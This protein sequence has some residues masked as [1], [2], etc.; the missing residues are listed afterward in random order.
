VD[1]S[2]STLAPTVSTM[3]VTLSPLEQ[4]RA[5]IHDAEKEFAKT[6]R[7]EF[8]AIHNRVNE[9]DDEINDSRLGDELLPRKLLGKVLKGLNEII[10]TLSYGADD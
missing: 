3:V 2:D 6:L 4:L 10:E 1:I 5:K 8:E 9:L 7:T